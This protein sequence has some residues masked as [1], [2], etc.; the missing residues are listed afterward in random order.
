MDYTMM[1]DI[2]VEYKDYAIGGKMLTAK[3]TVSQDVMVAKFSDEQARLAMRRSLVERLVDGILEN[4]MCEINQHMNPIDYSTTI[5]ARVY[6][7]PDDKVKLLRT[8]NV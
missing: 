1:N 4:K 5:I 3:V 8:L 7:A 2:D 6:V